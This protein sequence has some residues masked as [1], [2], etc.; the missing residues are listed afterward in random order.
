MY[1]TITQWKNTKDN[2]Y[3]SLIW[4]GSIKKWTPCYPQKSHLQVKEVQ[5]MYFSKFNS[6]FFWIVPK[7]PNISDCY[8]KM[9]WNLEKSVSIYLSS[10]KT[11]SFLNTK[12][13]WEVR[14][15]NENV[16]T[17][18]HCCKSN[19]NFSLRIGFFLNLNVQQKNPPG[20]YRLAWSFSSSSIN[21]S[22]ILRSSL[23]SRYIRNFSTF[24]S[25]Y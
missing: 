14:K 1:V 10:N 20:S 3:F 8:M 13:R 24:K 6:Q 19:N 25:K 5:V 18:L 9:R 11:W 12:K 21:S 16:W 2:I 15:M 23:H 17:H 22:K 7:K 4:K